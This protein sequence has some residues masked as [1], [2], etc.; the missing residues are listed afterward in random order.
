MSE[1]PEG[2]REYRIP[3]ARWADLEAKF[4][5]LARRARKL[6]VGEVSYK[7]ERVEKMQIVRERSQRAE[8]REKEIGQDEA[9][10]EGW[11][12]VGWASYRIVSVAGDRPKL[13]GWKFVGTLQNLHDDAGKSLMILRNVPG[14]VIPAKYR[15]AEQWCDHCKTRRYRNDTYVVVHEDGRSAQ[16]GSDCLKDFL[17]HQSPEQVARF[18]EYLMELDALLGSEEGGSG[19]GGGDGALYLPYVL[20]LAAARV[21]VKGWMS[22]SKAREVNG[23]AESYNREVEDNIVARESGESLPD[24]AKTGYKRGVE[25]TADA[26]G[27]YLDKN[28]GAKAMRDDGVELLPADEA[29]AEAALGWVRAMDRNELINKAD[30]GSDYL[31]NLYAACLRSDMSYRTLGIVASLIAAYQREMGRQ[32]ERKERNAKWANSQFVGAVKERKVFRLKLIE[33][34]KHYANDF[35]GSYLTR[36]EDEAGNQIV[37]WASDLIRVETGEFEEQGVWNAETHAVVPTKFPVTR[38]WAVGEWLNIKA[39]VVKHEERSGVKQTTI[40]RA[41]LDVPKAAKVKKEKK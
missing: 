3:E 18:C 10:P 28:K 32:A 25:A 39:T 29:E 8:P 23:E 33:E 14:E 26:V 40:N 30:G 15:D 6:G 4:E 13:N 19:G 20:A 12:L 31:W 11:F 34:P 1:N 9:I 7:I 21:R 22:R 41:A 16:V 24:G 17:G 35:G 2:P 36:L 27:L 38:P 5:K 37:W